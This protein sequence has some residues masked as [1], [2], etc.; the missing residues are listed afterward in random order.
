MSQPSDDEI[1]IDRIYE[2]L[3]ERLLDL[4][5]RNRMLNYPVGTRS[6]RQLVIV[7]EVLEDVHRMLAAEGA[8]LDILPMAEPDDIPTDERTTEFVAALDHGRVA[9]LDYVTRIQALEAS[10]RE[11][12]SGLA[13]AERALRDRVR[14]ELGMPPRPERGETDRLAQARRLGIEPNPEL[15]AAAYKAC[16]GDRNLQTLRYPDELDATLDRIAA[17]ARLAEQEMGV[18]TL[19]LALGFLQRYESDTSDRKYLAPLL[20]LPVRLEPRRVHGRRVWSLAATAAG[21]EINLSLARLLERDYG[22]VLPDFEVDEDGAASVEAY[23]EQVRETID[24]LRRWQVR[25][26]MVLGHFAFGRLAMYADLDPRQWRTPPA[27]TRLV[28]AVLRG[29]DGTAADQPLIPPDYAIDDPE[30]EAV[31]PY[32]IHDADASQHSAL[33]DVM[34]GRDL[35]VE[36]PPGTGKSQTITNVIANA[37]AA[38]RS[39]L[40]LAEKQAALDAVKKRLDT[41]GLGDFC[42]ELHSERAAP[43][44]V[45]DSLRRR[46]ELGWGRVPKPPLPRDVTLDQSR[47]EIADYAEALHARTDDGRTPFDLIWDA[48]A[49]QSRQPDIVAALRRVALPKSLLDSGARIAELRGRLEVYAATA[50]A[51]AADYGHPGESPWSETVLAD[52]APYDVG[53]LKDTIGALLSVVGDLADELYGAAEFGAKTLGDL[54]AIVTADKM[55]GTPPETIG[56]PERMA[57]VDAED[58]FR[59]AGLREKLKGLDL[60]LAAKPKLAGIPLETLAHATAMVTA[61]VD[62]ALLDLNPVAARIEA[63]RLVSEGWRAADAIER[64]MPVAEL[65]GLDRQATLAELD[66]LAHAIGFLARLSPPERA[67][68]GRYMLIEEREF[69][70]ARQRWLDAVEA[71]N[72]WRSAFPVYGSGPWPTVAEVEACEQ[73]MGRTGLTRRFALLTGGD[74][75]ARALLARLAGPDGRPPEAE[76]LAQFVVYLSYQ[77]ALERDPTMVGLFGP[78]WRGLSTPMEDCQQLRRDFR[79]ALAGRVASMTVAAALIGRFGEIGSRLGDFAAAAQNFRALPDEVRRRFGQGGIATIRA[80][81]EAERNRLAIMLDMDPDREL[82]GIPL[83]IREIAEIHGLLEKR[84]GLVDAIGASRLA[85]DWD[86]LFPEGVDLAEAVRAAEWARTVNHLRGGRATTSRLALDGLVGPEAGALRRRL[87]EVAHRVDPLLGR[88]AALRAT[89]EAD[90]GQFGLDDSDPRRILSR[91]DRLTAHRAELNSYLAI[92]K[93]RRE[94]TEAGL[95]EFLDACDKARIAPERLP[96]LFD[97]LLAQRRADDAR[98]SAP[99][100]ARQTGLTL[101]AMRHA[102]AERDRRK[103]ALDREAILGKLLEPTPPVGSIS[104][105]RG[106]WTD[107]A[108]LRNEFA[109]Q[110]RHLPVRVLLRRAGGAVQALKPCFMMSPLSLAKFLDPDGLRFDLLVID[111]AS[112]MRPED[113][114]G[115]LVRA[116]QVVV[117]GDPRQLPPTDFFARTGDHPADDADEG[118]DDVD[119]ESILDLCGRVFGQVRRLKWHY[120]SRCESLIAFSNHEFYDGGLI[121]FPSPR[122]DA[123]AIDL[124][125]VDGAYQAR[126]NVA[127]AIRIAEEAIGFM[128]AHADD[129]PAALPT[130]GLVAVNTD[131]RDLIAEELRRLETGDAD[132]ERYRAKAAARG[133]PVFVK[134][135]ENIQGD[136]R[137]VILIS[138]TYG[139][140]PGATAVKQRFGPIN[141]RHGHR[142]LNVL[143]TRAR[144]RIGLFASF[145]SEDVVLSDT[146]SRGLATLKRYLD[147]AERRG[148]APAAAT[149]AEPESPFEIEVARRLAERGYDVVPQVGVSGYRIDLG[150]RHPDQPGR[151]LAG[152]ECD[153][154]SYHSTRSARDR[155]RL[156]EEVLRGLGWDLIRVWST[157]WFEDAEEETNRLV[158]RLDQLRFA[159][160]RAADDIVFGA[161]TAALR[162]ELPPPPPDEATLRL[163]EMAEDPGPGGHFGFE[164]PKPPAVDISA[165]VPRHERD[166]ARALHDFRELVIAQRIPRFDRDRSI[167]RDTMIEWFAVNGLDDPL[168]WDAEVPAYLRLGTNPLERRL[169]LPEICGILDRRLRPQG[170]RLAASGPGLPGGRDGPEP[171]L[172]VIDG[173]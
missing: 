96:A 75:A 142:R 145:G 53:R 15:P 23:L 79:A 133:E 118:F 158:R 31:A 124:V 173:R 65:A 147:H 30:I 81:V 104:G 11:D 89:C 135:L 40:F 100:L 90:F 153:G 170:L 152:I 131:Q 87:G 71:E 156:R 157:D 67:L 136:E 78:V 42:L 98:R 139:R 69:L 144:R 161:R 48:V 59:V 22:R 126:R 70:A 159:P 112:Q 18:S 95:G 27:G 101:E 72:D 35:V 94:L 8:A 4:S 116:K 41:A 28:E 164:E 140:E 168:D 137:D 129:E 141:G 150:V 66:T 113:A 134:N 29:T 108:L 105:A 171:V 1:R 130:L 19:F 99:G 107:M 138:L 7:D 55:L 163:V 3:R 13:A 24:G 43:R 160:P 154:A 33:V 56:Q 32:L 20:L 123:F 128:R 103:I 61:G 121:T 80:E 88:F 44:L 97:T 114:L 149:G 169:F 49:G 167:L 76:E 17:D 38:G 148:R 9:D 62:A 83:P 14:D 122:P 127:E 172:A 102:F 6:R 60:A 63:D 143:F 166:L 93:L 120:R 54:Q 47:R 73:L 106:T 146:S 52:I 92:G 39:V 58:L 82:T 86:T 68:V 151:Y 115:G 162:A 64:M 117:V 91:L 74:K 125:R 36:G 37:I 155:D 25:R 34:R 85:Q 21:P 57:Q 109:K 165:A 2:G 110:R 46:A 132:V 10:G 50:R 51:F 12:E 45:V 16:H 5:N 84:Q 26:T 111:E 77:T 119:D